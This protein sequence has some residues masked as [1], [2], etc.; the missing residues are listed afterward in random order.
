MRKF[1]CMMVVL[2]LTCSCA[3]AEFVPIANGSTGATVKGIQS[4]LIELGYLEG[5]ADGNFGSGTEGAIKAFQEA[6]GLEV[7]GVVD[8]ATFNALYEGVENLITFR[9]CKWYSTKKDT[10]Q[11]LFSEG[12]TD[13]PL[14]EQHTIYSM[15]STDRSN[16]GF[17]TGKVEEG[18]YSAI[19]HDIS[20]AGYDVED[21][22]ACYIYPIVNGQ[23]VH[24]DEQ[25]E[26]YFGWYTFRSD[27]YADHE[28][29][30]N[31]LSTKLISIYGEGT[32]ESN[33][34]NNTITWIDVQ[35]NQIRLLIN[36]DK[37]YVTLGYIA[38]N[39]DERLD[40]MAQALVDEKV[41]QEAQSR[42]EN[43]SNTSGL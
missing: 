42:E 23:I 1:L 41:Q 27:D 14:I 35:G 11:I 3:L 6:K 28:G 30:Y 15:E 17:A 16:I 43:A 19:Y 40:A 5:A 26:F 25:A 24:D 21:T 12:A 10:E 34:D 13:G 4:R 32:V 36:N 18:G 22:Y 38:Y 9:N 37:N 39:A 7:S 29:I 20:V 33:D 8:E 31:D 2:A